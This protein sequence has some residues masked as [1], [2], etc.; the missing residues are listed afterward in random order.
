M[1]SRYMHVDRGDSNAMLYSLFYLSPFGKA[2]TI[3]LLMALP[4]KYM[5][6]GRDSGRMAGYSIINY[7]SPNSGHLSE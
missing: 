1:Y 4:L 2:L 5:G 6:V 7:H 3:E